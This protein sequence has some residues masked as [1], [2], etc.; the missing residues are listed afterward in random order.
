[1]SSSEQAKQ[2]QCWFSPRVEPRA[3]TAGPQAWLHAVVRARTSQFS[4][5]LCNNQN[6]S[7]MFFEKCLV[8][9]WGMVA[10]DRASQGNNR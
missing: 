4:S 6:R 5:L 9:A 10:A 7:A 3:S 2:V 8:L 1:M